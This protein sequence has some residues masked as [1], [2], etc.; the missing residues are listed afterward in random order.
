[1]KLW[2]LAAVLLVLGIGYVLISRPTIPSVSAN[3][4]ANVSNSIWSG[5]IGGGIN[6]VSKYLG[7]ATPNSAADSTFDTYGIGG[8]ASVAPG[9]SEVIGPEGY[10]PSME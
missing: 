7:K 10:H 9:V 5:I 8:T 6:A 3:E 4:Q 2:H 1:M